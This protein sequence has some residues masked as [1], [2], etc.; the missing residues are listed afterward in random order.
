M[1]A[2][3][4]VWLRGSGWP[5]VILAAASAGLFLRGVMVI[6]RQGLAEIYA[7]KI[8]AAEPAAKPDAA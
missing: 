1:G 6:A 3:G 7:L 2:A 5:D 4:A 8:A